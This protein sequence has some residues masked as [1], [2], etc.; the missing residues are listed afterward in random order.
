MAYGIEGDNVVIQVKVLPR[1]SKNQIVAQENGI[2]KVKVTAPPVEGEANKILKNLLAKSFGISKG[3]IDII[4]GER[5]RTKLI[6]IHGL[7]LVEINRALEKV[8]IS[9]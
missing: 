8:T 9:C 4:S 5:S 3:S 2:L 1:S 6:R 7:S